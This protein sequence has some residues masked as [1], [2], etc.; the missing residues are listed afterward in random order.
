MYWQPI[1]IGPVNIGVVAGSFN[2]YANT[3]NGGWFP[4]ILPAITIEGQYLGANLLFIPATN[5]ASNGVVSLQLKLKV[6]DSN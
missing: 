6:F 4:A 3:N 1:A 2:G 5:Q